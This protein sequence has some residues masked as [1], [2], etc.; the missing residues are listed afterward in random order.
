[1]TAFP[2]LAIV[3]SLAAAL[4]ACRPAG[5]RAS[6]QLPA[7]PLMHGTLRLDIAHPAQGATIDA[8]DSTFVYGSAGDGDAVVTVAGQSAHV[9]PNGAWIAWVAIPA[10]SAFEIPVV[11]RRGAD[12]VS[13]ML[14]LVRTGWVRQVGA[15]VDRR[16][17][18][19][20]GDVWMP[21]DEALALTVRAAPG[22]TVRLR[23][24]G[25]QT[26]DFA[27]DSIADPIPTAVRDFETDTS[28]IIRSVRGDRY[29]AMLRAAINPH[30]GDL[31]TTVIAPPADRVP[32]LEIALHGDTTRLPWPLAVTRSRGATIAVVLDDD[33]GRT[34]TTDRM[35]IGRAYPTGTYVWFLPEGT[36]TT[37]DMRVN[38]RV[39]LRLA[40]DAVAWVPAADVHRAAA[41]DDA[42]RAIMASL[43]AKVTPFGIELRIP[44]SRAIP[45][46]VSE[47]PDGVTI[48]LFDAASD[49][50]FT[51]YGSGD[52]FVASLTWRQA[53]ADRVEID[54]RFATTLWGWREHVDGT[55]L[56]F[57]FRKPPL[58]DAA[59]P[60]AGRRIV[61]DPGHPPEGACG[62]THLCEPEVNLAV[63]LKVR[64]LLRTAG[65]DVVLTRTGMQPV[66][67]WPRVALAD[68]VNADLLVSIHANGLP[69]GLDPFD[70]TGTTTFFNHPESLPLARAVQARL[71]ANLGL[72]DLGVV[73][74]DLAMVRPTWYPAVLTEGL[75]LMMPEQ[76][77][78]L[79]TDPGQAAYARSIVEGIAAFLRDVASGH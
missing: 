2:R 43:T 73:R 52:R 38:D 25:G 14:R 41:P 21:G 62:P 65:A 63:A 36:R 61:I 49:A 55:D 76:E 44:L 39:R 4:P 26:V 35:T 29:V 70:N 67:L 15:W 64:D 20:V 54:L 68:S 13:T 22:A 11:A 3:L 46:S 19:P 78:A 23:L 50:N 34:G 72:P 60:I 8:G 40:R 77:A 31:D 66:D 17:L 16:S 33:P 48:V 37:A 6:A 7:V 10:D 75:F 56:V 59:R 45:A 71:L 42:R 30:S 51:R 28:R 57:E 18:A 9:A 1:M 27:A 53:A 5:G 79:R 32:I 12:S 58:I 47:R 24:P 74:G 69:D